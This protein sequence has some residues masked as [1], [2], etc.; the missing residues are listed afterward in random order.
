MNDP[1]LA[2]VGKSRKQNYE[3]GKFLFNFHSGVSNMVLVLLKQHSWLGFR[4]QWHVVSEWMHPCIT[5]KMG[6]TWLSVGGFVP[7]Q[8]S[9]RD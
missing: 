4:K 6:S 8:F 2:S 5:N 1:K 9:V 3:K 7:I